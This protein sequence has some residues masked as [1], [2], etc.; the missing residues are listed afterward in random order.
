MQFCI[1]PETNIV[2][3]VVYIYHISWP[4]A[5]KAK[6]ASKLQKKSDNRMD[7]VVHYPPV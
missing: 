2:K 5:T 7:E 4:V 3:N 1:F 6:S